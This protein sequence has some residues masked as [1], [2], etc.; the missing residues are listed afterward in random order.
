M[1]DQATACGLELKKDAIS[2]VH[3]ASDQDGRLYDSR[4]GLGGYYRYGPRKLADLLNGEMGEPGHEVR[5]ERPKIHESVLQRIKHGARGYAPIGL[6]ADYR[7]VKQN[8][9]VVAAEEYVFPNGGVSH[10]LETA[11]EAHERAQA[12]ERVW[13]LVWGRRFVYFATVA[14]SLYL[15]S[16]PWSHGAGTTPSPFGFLSPAIRVAGNVPP[17]FAAR[18][19]DSFA[20]N[21]G[22]FLLGALL[23]VALMS[24]SSRIAMSLGDRMRLLWT[25][26]PARVASRPSRIYRVRMHPAYRRFFHWLKWYAAPTAFAG[27]L[28][29]GAI[30]LLS[31]S[32]FLVGSSFGLVCEGSPSVEVARTPVEREGFFTSSLCWPTGVAV[33]AGHRYRVTIRQ[34]LD[35]LDE[36]IA[37]PVDRAGF[38]TDQMTAAMYA[39]ILFRRSLG[40][41][42]F[43][44]IVRVGDVGNEVHPLAPHDGAFTTVARGAA[45]GDGSR[46]Q[47]VDEFV[48][49]RDGEVFLYV[50]D[51]VVGLPWLADLFY[52]NNRGTADI[53][54][55]PLGRV[56]G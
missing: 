1:M 3:L 8:G 21:P 32:A 34:G 41:A 43:A 27:L 20:A 5:I 24:W 17:G 12:Q 19:I 46:P 33:K 13:D 48:A 52:G 47:L 15:A 23:V 18:W 22:L 55:E 30:V 28:A 36:R 2:D 25:R 54:I 11:S 50:N 29:F 26:S 49:D 16:F 56:D 14:A 35:W 10:P 37:A 44:P 42:W 9:D 31:R 38:G 53:R 6:P 45:R 40:S 7:I 4:H 39:G 51:A